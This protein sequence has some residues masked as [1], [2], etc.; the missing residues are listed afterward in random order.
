MILYTL[1]VFFLSAIVFG[2][3]LCFSVFQT[4]DAPAWAFASMA[5]DTGCSLVC[6][7][8]SAGLILTLFYRGILNADVK[9]ERWITFTCS[10]VMWQWLNGV[11]VKQARRWLPNAIDSC[12]I[13]P[14]IYW[15]NASYLREP[16]RYDVIVF[17]V[18]RALAEC[19]R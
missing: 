2:L 13:K 4:Q 15:C 18:V 14:F 16:E 12:V 7:G 5:W 10:L 8:W 11:V 6:W 3:V 17:L 9:Q 19:S 1:V